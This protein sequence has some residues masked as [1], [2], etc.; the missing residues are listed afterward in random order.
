MIEKNEKKFKEHVNVFDEFK[1]VL[2]QEVNEAVRRTVIKQVRKA[3]QDMKESIPY[4]G[5]GTALS[6]NE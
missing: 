2:S 3:M 4:M 6:E 5:S 1:T